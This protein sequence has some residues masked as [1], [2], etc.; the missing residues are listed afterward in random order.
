[1]AEIKTEQVRE[2]FDERAA[3]MGVGALKRAA[4]SM[5]LSN[6]T[7][8]LWRAGRYKGDN[9]RV[10]E[11]VS[12][13]LDR[14][15]ERDEIGAERI[16]FTETSVSK[17]VFEVARRAHITSSM[18]LVCGPS[19]IGKTRAAKEY[20][21]RET[22]VILI[23]CHRSLRTREMIAELHRAVGLDGRGTV[24]TMMM[25]LVEKLRDTGRLII[26]DEAENL[27]AGSLDEIRRL[28]DWASVGVLYVGLERLYHNLSTL[29][30]DYAYITSR[31]RSYRR[32][33]GLRHADTT[34]IAGHFFDAMA[35]DRGGPQQIALDLHEVSRGN[36]RVLRDLIFDAIDVARANHA[37]INRSLLDAIA[38]GGRL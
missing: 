4:K 15:A 33:S 18:Y 32:L 1:M 11:A 14:V 10:A 30:G 24:H 35:C 29:K 31:I 27:S 21:R 19:G 17:A 12:A 5:G 16:P 20:A 2:R 22:D 37:K 25:G 13:W 36:A 6:A 38:Q 23:E 3:R 34:A 9:A 26:V 8:S 7:I 28:H